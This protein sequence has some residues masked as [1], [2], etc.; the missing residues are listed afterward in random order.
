MITVVIMRP[1]LVDP[2]RGRTHNLLPFNPPAEQAPSLWGYDGKPTN[3]RLEGSHT[4][5][6]VKK[7]EVAYAE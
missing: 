1:T 2:L 6:E 7:A 5:T 4:V 3:Q